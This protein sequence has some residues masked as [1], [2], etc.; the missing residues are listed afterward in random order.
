ME[1]KKFQEEV[2]SVFSEMAK[3]PNRKPHTKQSA[4]IHLTEEVGEIARQINNEYH[5]PEKFNKENLGEELADLMMFIVLIANFYNIDLSKKMKE[6]IE[7]VR[8]TAIKLKK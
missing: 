1:I 6:S 8:S 7:K 4:M 5:C 3:A 2:L